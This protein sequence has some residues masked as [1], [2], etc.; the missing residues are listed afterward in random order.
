LNAP[1]WFVVLAVVTS[2]PLIVCA[3]ASPFGEAAGRVDG[4]AEH[5]LS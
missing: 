2:W 4:D 3:A 5:R 1:A